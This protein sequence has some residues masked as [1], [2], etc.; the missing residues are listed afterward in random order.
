MQGR[1]PDCGLQGIEENVSTQTG[2]HSFNTA[3]KARTLLG[4]LISIKPAGSL[5]TSQI[6]S[7]PHGQGAEGLVKNN[8][9]VFSS[10]LDCLH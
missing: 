5:G 3:G 10:V 6:K 7:L 8:F 2:S 1:Y 9:F 4:P